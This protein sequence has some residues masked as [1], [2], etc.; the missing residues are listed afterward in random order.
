M[1]DEWPWSLMG[2]VQPE[3][4]SGTPEEASGIP[5]KYTSVV[6]QY[7]ALRIAPNMG[8]TLSVEQRATL[9][10]SYSLMQSELASVPSMPYPNST[11][12]GLGSKPQNR[13]FM[14]EGVVVE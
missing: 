13:P 9:S 10:R 3:Y 11:M 1:M 8:K 12:R 5:R 6:A 4:S 7:L 14:T 2:Y